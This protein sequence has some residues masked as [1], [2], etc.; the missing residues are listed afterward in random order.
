MNE[1]SENLIYKDVIKATLYDN[2]DDFCPLRKEKQM[3]YLFSLLKE[4]F[5]KKNQKILD[6]CCGYGRLIH[7]L[8]EFDTNQF[9]TGVDYVDELINQGKKHFTNNKNID[10]EVYDIMK[11][12]D[13]Y[14]KAF[15]ITINYKTLSWLPYYKTI[16]TELIKA[17]KNKIYITS[18][19]YDGDVDFIT[20]IYSNASKGTADNYT[21][22][23]TYSFPKF[24]K[25]CESIDVKEI[26]SINMKLD[27]DL[28]ESNNMNDLQT[29]TVSTKSGDRLEINGNVI[30]NWKLIQLIIN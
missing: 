27:F 5:E 22:L 19:F 23:N 4:D 17:T 20:K 29:Y 28:P 14:H 10:F 9:Y 3:D 24:K 7:F 6:A 8:N 21:Y 12:S 26:N 18:L 1:R 25:Y 15:D 13:K 11:L 2:K 30:L 16:L